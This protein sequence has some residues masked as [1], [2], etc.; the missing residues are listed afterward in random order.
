MFVNSQLERTRKNRRIVRNQTAHTEWRVPQDKNV[1][2][3]IASLLLSAAVIGTITITPA[4]AAI[5]SQAGDACVAD[6]SQAACAEYTYTDDSIVTDLS[7]LCKRMPFMNVCDVWRRCNV[8]ILESGVTAGD[9]YCEPWTLLAAGCNDGVTA[10]DPGMSTMSGCDSYTS[11]CGTV[12]S[13]VT[14]SLVPQCR[15]GGSGEH[16]ESS[17]SSSVAK[18]ALT[19]PGTRDSQK[20]VFADLCTQ[21]EMPGC[22]EC[23]GYGDCADPLTALSRVCGS[24]Y[25]AEC[26]VWHNMCASHIQSSVIVQHYCGDAGSF[27]APPLMRMY[28]HTGMKD[29]VLFHEWVPTDDASYYGAV[30]AIFLLSVLYEALVSG[31]SCLELY[32]AQ[33][34]TDTNKKMASAGNAAAGG[35][36]GLA[37]VE[38]LGGADSDDGVGNTAVR[39]IAVLNDERHVPRSVRTSID[40]SINGM[41]STVTLQVQG[42]AKRVAALTETIDALPVCHC[43]SDASPSKGGGGGGCRCGAEAAKAAAIAAAGVAAADDVTVDTVAPAAA[44]IAGDSD[45]DSDSDYVDCCA[46]K[47]APAADD[48]AAVETNALLSSTSTAASDGG[49]KKTAGSCCGG[50][51]VDGG[52]Y[53]EVAADATVI[54]VNDTMAVMPEFVTNFV[55]TFSFEPFNWRVSMVRMVYTWVTTTL[56][57]ALML[58]TMTFNVGLFFAVIAGLGVGVFFFS[59]FRSFVDNAHDESCCA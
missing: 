7:D 3:K 10:T 9:V 37:G 13:P 32:I 48:A 18:L 6:P 2:M 33:H 38:K 52:N 19:L 39:A 46:G 56:S 40:A 57:Y 30:V 35:S 14:T 17:S 41:A 54:N 29:Y 16:K 49:T 21:H 22:S 25:H 26:D 44:A 50:A 8:P 51:A 53:S 27:D 24:M 42:M 59:R 55:S 1:E 4:H 5:S 43:G 47:A 15:H 45:S 11:M 20:R 58:V 34:R 36:G 12:A 23:T 28:F 31:R